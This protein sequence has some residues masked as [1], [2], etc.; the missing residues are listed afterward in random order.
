M[1]QLMSA[2]GTKRT[3]ATVPNDV[4][5]RTLR[6]QSFMFAFDPKGTSRVRP[7]RPIPREAD[8]PP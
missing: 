6:F 5:F 4:R 8:R 7:L 1:S 3:F 2:F